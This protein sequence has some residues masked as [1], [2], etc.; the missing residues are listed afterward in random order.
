MDVAARINL[1]HP[2]S[3]RKSW[4]VLAAAVLSLA[5]LGCGTPADDA[6]TDDELQAIFE[7]LHSSIY[8]VYALP[9][10]RDAVYDLLRQSFAGDALTHEYIEHY[11]TLWRMAREDTRITILRVDYGDTS[12]VSRDGGRVEIEADWNVG[13]VVYHQG[14]S[15]A[16]INRYQA[17]YTMARVGDGYRIVDT[18]MKNMERVQLDLQKSNLGLTEPL[19]TSGQGMMSPSDLLR[20]GLMK[21]ASP[22]GAGSVPDPA[23]P[24]DAPGT[25]GGAAGRGDPEP[26]M[27]PG[28]GPLPNDQTDQEDR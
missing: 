24:G 12:V 16:R 6:I 9:Q 2:D 15:H 8:R 11:T 20:G 17:V 22:G 14:H 23:T 13:G 25:A 1:R 21:G 28:G 26:A 19:P 5:A 3:E 10:D 18:R 7:Q 27:T 4:R